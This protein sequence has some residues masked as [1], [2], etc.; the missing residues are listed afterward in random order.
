MCDTAIFHH[1]CRVILTGLA[2]EALNGAEGVVIGES[3]VN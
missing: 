3:Y 2:T 1:G